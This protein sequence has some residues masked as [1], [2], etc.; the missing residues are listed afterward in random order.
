METLRKTTLD[1]DLRKPSKVSVPHFIQ[2]DTNVI[3]FVIYESGEPADLANVGRIVVN[4]QRADRFVVSRLLSVVEGTSRIVYTVGSEEMAKAGVGN[5]ELQL[6]NADNSQRISTTT[7]KVNVVS[8]IGTEEI[9]ESDP[10]YTLLQTLFAETETHSKYAQEQGDYAKSRGDYAAQAADSVVTNWLAPVSN[11]AALPAG[12]LGDT[13]QTLDDGK[14]YRHDGQAWVYTQGYSATA[15][16]DVSAQLA[17]TETLAKPKTFKHNLSHIN[18]LTGQKAIHFLGA[19]NAQG[20]GTSDMFND[21]FVGVIR[22]FLQQEFDFKNIGFTNIMAHLNGGA[23]NEVHTVSGNWA[24]GNSDNEIGNAI[25][26]TFN[27]GTIMTVSMPKKVNSFRVYYRGTSKNTQIGVRVNGK[28]KTT[29]DTLTTGST[30]LCTPLIDV[31][32]ES[33]PYTIEFEKL[34]SNTTCVINGIGYYDDTSKLVFNNFSRSG[35]RLSN[36]P[37]ELLDHYADA[38]L[39]FYSL[40]NNDAG[41]SSI[42]IEKYTERL[43]YLKSKLIANKSDVICV[44]YTWGKFEVSTF[45]QATKQFADDLGGV[46]IDLYKELFKEAD[47]NQMQ[48]EGLLVDSSHLSI[49]GHQ[50]VSEYV[51]KRLGLSVTSKGT[52]NKLT[53]SD[54]ENT[55]YLIVGRDVVFENG[56]SNATSDSTKFKKVNGVV[57]LNVYATNTSN[58]TATAFTLPNGFRP[59][60]P[61]EQVFAQGSSTLYSVKVTTSGAVS[62]RGLPVG[63]TGTATYPS[64]YGISVS[65]LAR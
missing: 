19:S 63:G 42:T 4:Y 54:D 38:G 47:T 20:A 57:Y 37:N 26:Y 34:D 2:G 8:G 1:V 35:V 22:K 3:E 49:L 21:G 16:A 65:Y 61:F 39:V 62:F 10:Q 51:A 24:I 53:K 43:N 9:I 12:Q 48:T 50:L 32:G 60:V 31:K 30:L 28:L 33:Y 41:D 64:I 14:V 40:G 7:F 59:A 29:I 18:S 58:T 6:F 44:D 5:V 55:D 17:Q 52:A 46:Y 25:A 13:V 15:L 36:M 23:Y 27:A 45:K 56:Y 11:F